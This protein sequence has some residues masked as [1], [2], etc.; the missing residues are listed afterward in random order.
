MMLR[1]LNFYGRIRLLLLIIILIFN[2]LLWFCLIFL[3][4]FINL[5]DISIRLILCRRL[6]SNFSRLAFLF[7]LNHINLE[8]ILIILLNN[9]KRPHFSTVLIII[10]YKINAIMIDDLQ[11]VVEPIV[12]KLQRL[13]RAR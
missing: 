2:I 13:F 10:K 6:L 9:T 5:I 8:N 3:L 7:S 1:G 11:E 4:Y 12:M